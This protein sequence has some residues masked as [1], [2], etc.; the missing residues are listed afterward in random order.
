M[1]SRRRPLRLVECEDSF[2][3]LWDQ[4]YFESRTEGEIK[5]RSLQL[6]N[7]LLPLLSVGDGFRFRY[8]DICVP[9]FGNTETSVSSHVELRTR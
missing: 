8:I 4:P 9:I 2:L 3:G 6:G 1:R 5:L 7:L